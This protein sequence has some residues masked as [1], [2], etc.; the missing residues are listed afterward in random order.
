MMKILRTEKVSLKIQSIS[1]PSFK[2]KAR[3]GGKCFATIHYR[4]AVIN[5]DDNA[6][7]ST[8]PATDSRQRSLL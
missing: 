5:I 6:L 3:G 2:F 1:V 8:G 4:F 7:H